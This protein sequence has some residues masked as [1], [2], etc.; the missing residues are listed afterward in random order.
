MY[1]LVIPPNQSGYSVSVGQETISTKLDG[2]ASRFRVD[3]LNAS[4][5]VTCSWTVGPDNYEYL[6]RFYLVNIKNGNEPFLIDLILD[7][8][9]PTQY[10]ARFIP[11]SWGLTGQQGHTYTVGCQL[12]IEAIEHD[13]DY[14][15]A[16]IMLISEYGSEEAALEILNLLDK[17]VNHDLPEINYHG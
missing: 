3:I 6:R 16:I 4:S 17:L 2:G 12:E 11:G 9:M 14:D 10:T 1:K 13:Y 5:D 7:S 8:P 15:E